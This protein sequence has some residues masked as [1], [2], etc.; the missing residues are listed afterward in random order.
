MHTIDD[1]I[2]RLTAIVHTAEQQQ[3]PMGYFA[4]LYRCMTIA[5]R[6][7]IRQGRF[8][9]ARRMEALDVCFAKRYIDAYNTYLAGRKPTQAWQQAFASTTNS[10]IT[11]IQHL[12]L[13]INAHINLDLAIAAAETAPGA[14]IHGLQADFN[15]INAMIAELTE[16]VQDKLADIW[17]PFRLLDD[18]LKT[19]DEGMINFS[20]RVARTFSWSAAVALAPM[21]DVQKRTKIGEMDRQVALLAER[22]I[23]PGWL[24]SSALRVIRLGESGSV[25]EKIRLLGSAVTLDKLVNQ[26]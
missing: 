2:D 18:A 1:V 11:V 9:D 21:T 16:Q 3:S 5:V 17:L 24:L 26:A 19:D 7:G 25:T 20:I 23:R 13:G 10:Q 15:R 12:M 8:D 6:D 22:I 4:A 14:A